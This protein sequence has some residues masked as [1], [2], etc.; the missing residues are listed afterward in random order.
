MLLNLPK[1]SGKSKAST[2]RRAQTSKKRK[3]K[4]DSS[5][6]DE[7]WRPSDAED[8]E[9]DEDEEEA[10]DKS[11]D[12]D[13][14]PLSA[15]QG[16]NAARPASTARRAAV[17]VSVSLAFRAPSAHQTVMHLPVPVLR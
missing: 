12:E 3:S 5:G 6:S 15:R 10:A 16:R 4:A 11:S 9:E 7:E 8:E 1:S 14:T 17:G 13:E 2:S